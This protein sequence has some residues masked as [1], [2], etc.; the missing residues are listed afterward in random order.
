MLSK[1]TKESIM[2]DCCRVCKFWTLKDTIP[3]DGGVGEHR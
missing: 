3:Q 1:E 2:K